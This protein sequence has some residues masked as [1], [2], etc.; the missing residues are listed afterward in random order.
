MS[1]IANRVQ[2]PASASKEKVGLN[3]TG[4]RRAW[5]KGVSA[6]FGESLLKK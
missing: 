3:H 2:Q 6:T 5:V 1:G 4:F